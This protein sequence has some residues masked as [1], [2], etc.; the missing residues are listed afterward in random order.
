MKKGKINL[1]HVNAKDF[2]NEL[3]TLKS[4]LA[5]HLLNDM[6]ST[7]IHLTEVTND[8]TTNFLAKKGFM[9]NNIDNNYIKNLI[10]MIN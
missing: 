3:Q 2:I 4:P 8:L 10:D 5:S 6:Q 7:N 1:N 9:W